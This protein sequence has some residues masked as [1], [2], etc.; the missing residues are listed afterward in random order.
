MLA[1]VCVSL[2]WSVLASPDTA[3]RDQPN[4]QGNAETKRDKHDFRVL[5]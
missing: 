4:F 1:S 5:P 3:H 2:D